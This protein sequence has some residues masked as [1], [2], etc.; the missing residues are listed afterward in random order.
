MMRED[1]R[2]QRNELANAVKLLRD[3]E[4]GRIKKPDGLTIE[5]FRARVDMALDAIELV[6][7]RSGKIERE[8]IAFV[9]AR[10][11]ELDTRNQSLLSNCE[12]RIPYEPDTGDGYD[13]CIEEEADHEDWCDGC[14]KAHEAFKR[15][16]RLRADRAN[17]LR[18]LV[19]AV[20]ALEPSGEGGE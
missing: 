14:V 9:K 16:P 8:A 5:W 3:I 12:H 13:S 15:L 11:A 2:K 7:R 18:R 17:A 20:N 10:R 4:T 19:R 1:K 6:E